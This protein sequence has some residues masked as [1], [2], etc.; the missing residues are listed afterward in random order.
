MV[1]YVRRNKSENNV[2]ASL[3][4]R[5]NEDYYEINE[6]EPVRYGLTCDCK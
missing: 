1:L 2:H 6:T 3:L 4:A 5:K